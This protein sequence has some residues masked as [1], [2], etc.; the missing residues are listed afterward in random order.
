MKLTIIFLVAG[1][2]N[3]GAKTLSQQ[4]SFSGGNASLEEVFREV[5]KQTGYFFFCNASLLKA[6]APVTIHVK[7]M[8]LL[9][10]LDRV[11]EDQPLS[12]SIEKKNIIIRWKEAAA[13]DWKLLEP[14]PPITVKGR[15]VNENGN[16]VIV[17]VLVKGS[18]RGTPT[19]ENGEFVLKN[20][21][22]NAILS[23]TGV[24]IE[25]L[26][27]KVNG[28]TDIA[29]IKV[30]T[31]INIGEEVLL[32]SNGYQK[33]RRERLTGA[34]ASISSKT[35]HQSIPVTGNILANLEGRLPGLVYNPNTGDEKGKGL[36][37]RGVSTLNADT[38][39]LIILNGFP[40]EI[41]LNNIEPSEIESINV[42][43]DAAAAAI[44]GVRS[45]NGV[46]II[47][48]TKG[49]S[50]PPRFQ[51]SA[52]VTVQP[53]A[54]LSFYEYLT[55]RDYVEA[56]RLKTLYTMSTNANATKALYDTKNISYTPVFG[57]TDDLKNGRITQ[58]QADAIFAEYGSYDNL[59]DYKHL[60]L[61]NPVM[62]TVD[63]DISGGNPNL[64]Y[65]FGVNHQDN[66]F[67]QK[68]NGN[69]R[70]VINY[71]GNFK[72]LR[73]FSLDV[74]SFYT[75]G[76]ATSAPSPD[77][78]DFRPYQR[79]TDGNGKPVA[80]YFQPRLSSLLGGTSTG[81]VNDV[82]ANRAL[83]KGLYDPRY[84]PYQELTGTSGKRQSNVYHFQGSLTTMLFKGLNLELGGMFEKQLS[85]LTTLATENAFETRMAM[86][87]YASAE[88]TSGLP[89][90]QFPRGAIK[91]TT[92]NSLKSYTIRAQL[93]YN[94]EFGKHAVTALF[95]AEQRKIESA[96]MLSTAFGYDANTLM[97]QQMNLA[98]FDGQAYASAF[99]NDFAIAGP[100]FGGY[101]FQ[102]FFNETFVDNRFVSSY[103]NAA[104][105]YNDKYTATGSFRI[106]Q[107]NLFGT[108][109]KFRY[110]PLW[111][112]GI[113]WAVHKESFLDKV[114]W[115]SKLNLRASIGYNGNTASGAGPSTTLQAQ[116]NTLSQ[117]NPITAYIIK[118]PSN[119]SLRW[120]KTLNYNLGLDFSLLQDRLFAGIDY[121][122]KNSRDL[123]EMMNID[124]TLGGN[125]TGVTAN[126]ASIRNKG[127]E[128][129]VNSVNVRKKN[130]SWSTQAT[131]S[132]NT[133][134]VTDLNYI[135]NVNTAFNIAATSSATKVKGYSLNPLFA[136]RYAG[137]N[138]LGQPTMYQRDGKIV[139]LNANSNVPDTVVAYQGTTDP[140]YVIGFNNQLTFHHFDLNFL[141]MYY[142]G[143]VGYIAPPALSAERPIQG[144]LNYW[145]K[146][147]DELVTNNPGY[148]PV[149]TTDPRYFNNYGMAT[150]TYG[151]IFYKRMDYLA[152]RNITLSYN[153]DH[154]VRKMGLSNTR[155]RIQV[156]NPVKYVFNGEHLDPETMNLKAGTRSLP[157]VKSYTLS[158]STNF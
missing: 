135:F 30:M 98:L 72:F 65:L 32:V 55:G 118:S 19:N 11:F 46:I 128:I 102:N 123:I 87:L 113:L 9:Q 139:V 132:F 23:I 152:L 63:L 13:V 36:S 68:L 52:A 86:N 37:I 121:Y 144:A 56:E 111:S 28:R 104:Y 73:R 82:Q 141:I 124:P 88:P 74:Q 126:N 35:Y 147:G 15:I 57:A 93:N 33:I 8:P 31:R 120:E 69:N 58:A 83:A 133:N 59:N 100:F 138:A 94:A 49:Q 151:A 101:S 109:P 4:V 158:I 29:V 7:A 84:Y 75:N 92:N 27:I 129:S 34:V 153:F 131:A 114:N 125:G 51:F 43:K 154:I 2:L 95:G 155:I 97:Y 119:N 1:L 70:T 106:D 91:Y 145:K 96:G 64:Y 16:P 18:A 66:R 117:P 105:T 24:N 156:Q 136:Y 26:E 78:A 42:L 89:V 3:G 80:A 108:D 79:F 127:L 38:K 115:L 137:L 134:K 81:S 77:Y 12:F 40:T 150:Y 62:T 17:S 44:Y 25:P 50:G 112:A 48:T 22:A 14:A 10:F 53:K 85:T 61:Q 99:L 149:S 47:T 103:G 39:P 76:N 107:S 157:V 6:A 140:R 116:K 148:A 60:F 21:D 45:S 67:G 142:G 54:D 122:V 130:F 71:R 143:H 90:F 20:I 41:D 5:E 146:P 110:V